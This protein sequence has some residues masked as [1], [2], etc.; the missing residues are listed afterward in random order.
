MHAAVSTQVKSLALTG[1]LLLGVLHMCAALAST[2][3]LFHSPCS[4]ASCEL[5]L[6]LVAGPYQLVF[7]KQ[8]DDTEVAV[9]GAGILLRSK[10]VYLVG[11]CCDILLL[12]GGLT[13][14]GDQP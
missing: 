6:S 11:G 1:M 5:L 9:V 14:M 12:N 2:I 13:G 7:L 3:S 8:L 4:S 10:A